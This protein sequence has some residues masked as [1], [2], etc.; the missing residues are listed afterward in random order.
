MHLLYKP[1]A[2]GWPEQQRSINGL[3]SGTSKSGGFATGL[4]GLVDRLPD[5]GGTAGFPA[6]K[7]SFGLEGS[8]ALPKPFKTLP[9]FSSSV[10]DVF[11]LINDSELGR[12]NE[13]TGSSEERS[14]FMKE[15]KRIR[16]NRRKR[17]MKGMTNNKKC[18]AHLSRIRKVSQAEDN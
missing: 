1:L 3:Q 8:I 16:K 13:V 4:G 15:E 14:A 5:S 7:I 18:H 9:F 17:W 10:I 2:N 12:S 6:P 11:A